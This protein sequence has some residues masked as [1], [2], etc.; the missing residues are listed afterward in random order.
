[1]NFYEHRYVSTISV[2][3]HTHI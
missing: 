2:T 1:M 3:P